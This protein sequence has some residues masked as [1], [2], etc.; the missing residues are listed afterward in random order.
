MRKI[1][2]VFD[3]GIDGRDRRSM[4]FFISLAVAHLAAKGRGGMGHG[5]GGI[6][7]HHLFEN[8]SEFQDFVAGETRRRALAKLNNAEKISLGL[9]LES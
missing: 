3:E 5:D 2:Q 6:A 1:Y 4:G 8:I 7:E 9:P